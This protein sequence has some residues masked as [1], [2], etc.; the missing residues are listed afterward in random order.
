MTDLDNNEEKDWESILLSIQPS[1]QIRQV[2][3]DKKLTR[4][5]QERS[6]WLLLQQTYLLPKKAHAMLKT[7][8]KPLKHQTTMTI[9]TGA[10]ML[11]SI[12]ERHLLTREVIVLDTDNTSRYVKCLEKTNPGPTKAEVAAAKML[13]TS[14]NAIMLSDYFDHSSG[15]YA[16]LW[17]TNGTY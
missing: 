13:K 11:N 14:D 7:R 12:N 17:S 2:V 10:I 1:A 6:N 8:K 4:R 15:D 16:P 9:H 5:Q 3:I